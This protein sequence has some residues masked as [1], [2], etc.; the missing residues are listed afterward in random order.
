[1]GA[2]AW[3]LDM[4]NFENVPVQ[5]QG[6]EIANQSMLWS[7]FINEGVRIIKVHATCCTSHSL[8]VHV[9]AM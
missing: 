4:A 1:M 7:V 8:L 5:L 2:L 3:G 6:F 9:H